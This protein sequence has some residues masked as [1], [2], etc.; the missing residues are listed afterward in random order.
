M[1]EYGDYFAEDPPKPR[2]TPRPR[3]ARKRKG[4][5]SGSK[6]KYERPWVEPWYVD[7][8][9][10]GWRGKGIPACTDTHGEPIKRVGFAAIKRVMDNPVDLTYERPINEYALVWCESLGIGLMRDGDKL[11]TAQFTVCTYNNFTKD[12]KGAAGRDEAIRF[13]LKLLKKRRHYYFE[14]KDG[15]KM[16]SPPE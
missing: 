1:G 9:K 11:P 2:E 3:P 4:S 7:P 8:F 13:F 15:G 12:F 14:R 10:P 16:D 5:G 6:G